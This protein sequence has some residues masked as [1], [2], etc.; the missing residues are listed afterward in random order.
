MALASGDFTI[1][2]RTSTNRLAVVRPVLIPSASGKLCVPVE[3]ST[4]ELSLIEVKTAQVD[5]EFAFPVRLSNGA[6]ALVR[7]AVATGGSDCNDCDPAIPD[8][9]NITVS[10]L[11]G[12]FA[13]RNGVWQLDWMGGC[14]WIYNAGEDPRT[15]LHYWTGL[16]PHRWEFWVQ[17]PSR[18]WIVIESSPLITDECDPR[19]VYDSIQDC[20]DLDCPGSCSASAGVS[21]TVTY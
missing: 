4:G 19:G 8:I 12:D 17:P 2:H 16:V 11:G 6:L 14:N 18:C 7:E 10:G 21:V 3:L 1:P 9:L 13:A 5:D 20:L 15:V